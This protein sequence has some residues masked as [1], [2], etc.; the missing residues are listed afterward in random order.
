MYIHYE[1]V[2]ASCAI[3]FLVENILKFQYGIQIIVGDFLS[4]IVQAASSLPISNVSHHT[5]LNTHSF[6]KI[7]HNVIQMLEL[8]SFSY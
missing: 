7:F 5:I 3:I 8:T 6:R 4:T 1:S 2:Q